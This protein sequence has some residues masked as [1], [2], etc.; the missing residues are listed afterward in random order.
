MDREVD[1]ELANL[2]QP[3]AVLER[4]LNRGPLCATPVPILAAR[5]SAARMVIVVR[6]TAE[7]PRDD[8]WI[9]MTEIKGVRL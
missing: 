8:R 9:A 7:D 1:E 6:R 3:E 5:P 2:R 4:A